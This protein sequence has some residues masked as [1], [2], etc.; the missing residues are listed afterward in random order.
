MFG[1]CIRMYKVLI[2]AVMAT[3]KYKSIIDIIFF[4]FPLCRRMFPVVKISASGLDPAAM[5]TVLLEFV[6]VD[7]HRWKYVNGEWVRLF[8]SDHKMHLN[9]RGNF[10]LGSWWQS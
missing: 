2:V 1:G 10:V 5:Y 8:I 4:L 7:S 6:Q 3:K 9:Y